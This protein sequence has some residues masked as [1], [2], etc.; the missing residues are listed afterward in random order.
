MYVPTHRSRATTPSRTLH[1]LFD[2]GGVMVVEPS[3]A[4]GA[5]VAISTW[6]CDNPGCD[7]REVDVRTW[8]VEPEKEVTSRPA[9]RDDLFA[10]LDLDTA[11]LSIQLTAEA[12]L[13][14][15]RLTDLTRRAL[16]TE[17]LEVLRRRWHRVKGQQLPDEWR[18]VDWTRIDREA[19]VPFM[20]VVPSRWDLSVIAGDRR[21][22]AVDC[23]CLNPACTCEEIVVDFVEDQGG[24]VGPVRI[25]VACWRL[26]DA[27]NP[28][29]ADLAERLLGDPATRRELRARHKMM[30]GVAREL[31]QIHHDRQQSAAP[32]PARNAPCPC[33]S[34]K[35]YKR[36]CGRSG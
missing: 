32:T 9:A 35:K 16:R 8:L 7:C 21:Y 36:C 2:D 4:P 3:E 13:P 24:T 10:K 12:A 33:G 11:T 29:G 22:W 19:L 30:R 34:G 17:V 26:T 14:S 23:W 18:N 6:Y 25:D 5:L 20:E 27:G 31:P 15:S 1:R 28:R